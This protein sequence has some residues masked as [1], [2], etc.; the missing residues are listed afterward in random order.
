MINV[1][2]AQEKIKMYCINHS[3]N[4]TLVHKGILIG[5]MV[6]PIQNKYK[7]IIKARQ[8]DGFL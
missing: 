7:N 3:V 5:E 2:E 6:F 8:Q 1:N 4:Q